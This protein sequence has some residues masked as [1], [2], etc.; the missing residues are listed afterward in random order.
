MAVEEA[1]RYIV[2]TDTQMGLH[3]WQTEQAL[4]LLARLRE[5]RDARA[6]QL[7]LDGEG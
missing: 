4:A 1:A 3:T 2:E 5:E 6:R 7:S